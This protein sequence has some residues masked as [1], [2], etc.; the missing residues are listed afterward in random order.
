M[1]E[2]DYRDYFHCLFPNFFENE[3]LR[4]LPETWVAEEM[5]LDLHDFSA[6]ALALPCPERISFGMYEGEL[7]TLRAAVRRVDE[8]WV[9]Y[10]NQGDPVYCAFEDGEA[11]AFCQLSD[12]GV[13]QGRKVGGPG[14]VGTVPSCRKRGIGLKMVLNA[15]DILKR[16]GYDISHIHFTKVA[17]WYARLG[18]K[19][20]LRW[21]GKGFLDN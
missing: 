13:Y 7:E 17:P 4:E 1:L 5:T 19:T 16:Q 15:T 18:Y 2:L 12:F 9:Q 3:F 8:S 21:N 11:V 14:C 10:F 20:V 6:D